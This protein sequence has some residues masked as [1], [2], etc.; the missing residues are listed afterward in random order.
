[1][2]AQWNTTQLLK[3][4]KKNEILPSETKQKLGWYYAQ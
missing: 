1:M 3:K 2:Y 4:K